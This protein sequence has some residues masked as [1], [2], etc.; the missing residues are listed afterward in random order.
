MASVEHLGQIYEVEDELLRDF[1][2]DTI[3]ADDP[4]DILQYFANLNQKSRVALS[5][6]IVF[7]LAEVDPGYVA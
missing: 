6:Y 1:F 2:Y 3:V 7:R 4:V 5:D